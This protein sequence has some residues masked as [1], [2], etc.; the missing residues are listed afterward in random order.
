MF[1]ENHKISVRQL[2]SMLLLYYFSTAV[3]FLPSEA[4]NSAGN[5]CWIV[6]ILWGV[7]SSLLAVFLVYLG[8]R[9]PSYTAVEW[10]EY[11]FGRGLGTVLAFGLAG[12]LVFDGAMELRLFC[13]IISSSM[14]PRTPLWLLILLTLILC[15]ITAAHGA[16]CS[17][18]AAEVLFF[19]VFVPLI[20]VL[21][22]V[23]ISAE[24]HRVL[25]IEMPN[26]HELKEGV[27]FFGQLF[28]GL[29]I[30][31]FMFPYLKK[32]QH[33]GRRIWLTCLLATAALGILVFLSLA[34]YG[35]DVLS[36]KMLPT[37][38]MMERVSFSGIFLGRQDLF[39][40][41]FWMVTTFLFVAILIFFGGDL[42]TRVFKS[43]K[44]Q[45]NRWLILWCPLIFIVALLPKD[46]ATVYWVRLRVAPW[47]NGVFFILLPLITLCIDGIK[48]RGK[49]E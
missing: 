32:R 43:K 12:K 30:F 9:H 21:I 13:D 31:L 45:R 4:A 44:Q 6:T 34:V 5:S 7:A 16:E 23:A 38:Q 17:A 24:Y 35:A 49:H 40:L 36:E 26:L 48:G 29:G 46:M 14:L 47:L 25:P 42:C 18:R 15:S 37:L 33:L 10:Y 11:S 3:L 19:V 27:P 22:F 1:A 8:G 39:L 28:Q 20:L 2:E 41:W